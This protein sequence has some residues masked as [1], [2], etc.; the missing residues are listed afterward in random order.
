[1]KRFKSVGAAISGTIGGDLLLSTLHHI[2]HRQTFHTH[3]ITKSL[4]QTLD[5]TDILVAP[6][7]HTRTDSS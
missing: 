6:N 3:R 7:I 4:A 1:M 2:R 5:P